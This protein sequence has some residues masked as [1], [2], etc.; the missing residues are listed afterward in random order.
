MIT[1]LDALEA[2]CSSVGHSAP[3]DIRTEL[4]GSEYLVVFCFVT[5]AERR[6]DR[7]LVA[8]VDADSGKVTR[9][10]AVNKPEP[11]LQ[12]A[13]ENWPQFISPK[14]A[15]DIALETLAGLR[16]YYPYGQLRVELRG[17]RYYV[18]FPI[19]PNPGARG[20]D[21]TVQIQLD[22]PTGKVL[23]IMGPN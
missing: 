2:A 18:T 16:P 14:R 4:H 17:D 12:P 3:G 11:G 8:T 5:D 6:Q 15:Y 21:Y 9:T 7:I 1:S 22:A 13:A 20:A 23:H 10:E 19:K